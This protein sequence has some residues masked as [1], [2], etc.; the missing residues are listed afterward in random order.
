[1]WVAGCVH[2]CVCVLGSQCNINLSGFF[3]LSD[4]LVAPQM[5]EPQLFLL[6]L[7]H[8]YTHPQIYMC[9]QLTI[10]LLNLSVHKVQ[11]HCVS[12]RDPQLS[13]PSIIPVPIS[14]HVSLPLLCMQAGASP[15]D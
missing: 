11:E 1:M 13:Y 6:L 4:A 15:T 8:T 7:L 12:A 5:H 9:P 3:F 2:V 10:P 14:H